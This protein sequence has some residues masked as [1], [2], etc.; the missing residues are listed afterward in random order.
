[1]KKF[2][3]ATALVVFSAN[4]VF[5]G[6]TN[7]SAK[8]KPVAGRLSESAQNAMKEAGFG[9]EQVRKYAELGLKEM[10]SATLKKFKELPAETKTSLNTVMSRSLNLLSN[11]RTAT[12][13]GENGKLFVEAADRMATGVVDMVVTGKSESIDIAKIE[14]VSKLLEE[15]SSLKDLQNEGT[16]A[17]QMTKISAELGNGRTIR[18]LIEACKK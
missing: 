13:L 12:N 4:S 14:R 1:M 7:K 3:I 18:D 17:L 10:D 16:L 8:P 5:A 15:V 11:A 9:T 2:I 6:P